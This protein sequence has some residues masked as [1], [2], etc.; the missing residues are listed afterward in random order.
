[1]VANNP[2][3]SSHG[4][5]APKSVTHRYVT[6]DV[7]Y[8]LVPMLELASAAGVQAP[9]VDAVVTMWS[10]ILDRN[11]R[12]DGRTMKRLGLEGMSVRQIMDHAE[13]GF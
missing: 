6:E 8:L 1:M 2:A 9:V 3:Y 12:E 10:A 5:D 11:F 13:R 4:N 7:P